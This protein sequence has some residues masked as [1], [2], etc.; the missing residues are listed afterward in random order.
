MISSLLRYKLVDRIPWRQSSLLLRNAGNA[1]W[2]GLGCL[3]WHSTSSFD[4]DH[5]ISR[6]SVRNL[7]READ[8]LLTSRPCLV[9]LAFSGVTVSPILLL[10]VGV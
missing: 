5:L 8:D 10:N 6:T 4:T 2:V 7:I 1:Y 9:T 3:Y